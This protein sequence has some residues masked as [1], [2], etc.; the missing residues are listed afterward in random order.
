MIAKPPGIATRALGAGPGIE[1]DRVVADGEDA[2]Q[3]V[4]DDD[5]S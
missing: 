3:L 5:N 1:K 2:G 4:G